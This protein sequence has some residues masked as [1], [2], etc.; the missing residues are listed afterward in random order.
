M[1]TCN[2]SAKTFTVFIGDI[3]GCMDELSALL[4]SL[5]R[6]LGHQTFTQHTQLILL[7]DLIGRGPAAAEVVRWAY[8]WG[9]I[10]LLGNHEL[11]Y[12]HTL[13][14]AA[15]L[16]PQGLSVSPWLPACLTLQQQLGELHHAFVTKF[17]SYY[18][19][20][21]FLAVHAGIHPKLPLH[22]CSRAFLCNVRTIA[23]KPWHTYYKGNKPIIYGH[24]AQQGLTRTHNTIGLDSGCVYG[25]KL[26]AYILEL[27]SIIQVAAHKAYAAIAHIAP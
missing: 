24:W 26:S 9:A 4:S 7:G 11:N 27:D 12:L 17:K 19:D 6:R 13:A 5:E 10:A 21:R 22:E 14:T 20:A 2:V 15:Q 16:Q 1:Q 18:E 8:E 25:G 23:G 3:H